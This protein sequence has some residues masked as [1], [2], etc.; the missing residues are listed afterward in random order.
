MKQGI[1][2]K[3]RTQELVQQARELADTIAPGTFDTVA[4]TAEWKDAFESRLVYLIVMECIDVGATAWIANGYNVFP[5][6]R[7]NEHFF[8]VT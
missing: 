7:I 8:E 6:D 3:Q 4:A 2:M 5:A 1:E